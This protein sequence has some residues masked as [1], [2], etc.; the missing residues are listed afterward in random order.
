MG[1]GHCIDSRLINY[2]FV[3]D[4]DCDSDDHMLSLALESA[5]VRNIFLWLLQD[6]ICGVEFSDYRLET[7][8]S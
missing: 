3:Y 2:G 4:Y 7:I 8:L 1:D 5:G 6:K